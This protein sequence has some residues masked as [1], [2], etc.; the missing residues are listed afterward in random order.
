[1]VHGTY[2]VDPRK[3]PPDAVAQSRI[4]EERR[5]IV[6]EMGRATWMSI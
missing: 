2:Q 5:M 3:T 4:R 6:P 1:M